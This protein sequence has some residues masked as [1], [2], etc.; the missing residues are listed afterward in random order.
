MITYSSPHRMGQ[1]PDPL[2]RSLQHIFFLTPRFGFR[3]QP[4]QTQIAESGLK[5]GF[6]ETH[7]AFGSY[8]SQPNT[9]LNSVSWAPAFPYISSLLSAA[10]H[11]QVKCLEGLITIKSNQIMVGDDNV[12]REIPIQLR[13]KP[14]QIRCKSSSLWAP[15]VPETRCDL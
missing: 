5:C 15:L 4:V 11:Y 14:C 10:N 2:R 3:T 7:I 8:L 1:V 6:S 13:H 12:E 9:Q